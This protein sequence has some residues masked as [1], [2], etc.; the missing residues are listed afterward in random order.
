LSPTEVEAAKN[1]LGDLENFHGTNFSNARL[2]TGNMN[3]NQQTS[4]YIISPF[5][6]SEKALEY[7]RKFSADF[8]S[9]GL[10]Q[11]AKT[12]SFFISIENFQTLNKSKNLEEYLT[13]FRSIYQ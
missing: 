2:R 13:F 1:L 4:I 9:E 5:A 8:S 6:N 7:Y 10:S 11:E 12:N 3:M